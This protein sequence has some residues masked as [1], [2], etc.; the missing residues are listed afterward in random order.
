MPADERFT[1][2][3]AQAWPGTTAEHL[4]AILLPPD[5]SLPAFEGAADAITVA[6]LLTRAEQDLAHP[7][8]HTLAHAAARYVRDGDREEYQEQLFARQQRLSR[9]V[10]AAVVTESPQWVDEVADGVVLLCEQSSWCWPAHDDTWQRHGSVLPSVTDPYLDLGAGEV[11]GQ[12]AWIDHVLG[13]SLDERFPGLRSRIRHETRVRVI[14]PFLRRRDWQWLGLDGHVNNWNP[15]IHGNVLV[16]A[17]RLVDDLQLRATVVDLAIQGLDRYVA[18]LPVD[19]AIDEGY[20]YWWNGACRAVEALDLLRH[21]TAGQLD[22]TTIPALRE[23]LAFPHRM[24]LA[25][26]WYLNLADGQARPPADQPW[27]ALHRAALAIGAEPAARHAAVHRLPGAPVANEREGL[28]RLLRALGDQDWRLANADA[29]PLPRDVWLESIQVL[30]ARPAEGSAQGL[31]LAVKGGHNGEHHNHNDVGQVVI[32][33][34]GVPMVVDAGRTTYN[35][36][37]FG[38]DRYLIPTMNSDWHSVPRI[39]ADAQ[40]PG[41]RYAARSLEPTITDTVSGLKLD[42]A[43]A[44]PGHE[45][46][47]WFRS[48]YLDRSPGQVVITD[49]WNLSRASDE[50][51]SLVRYI[52]ASDVHLVPG[53]ATIT[54]E[55]T[56]TLSWD[57]MV[58]ATLDVLHLEDQMLS[59]VWGDRL[60]RLT[61]DVGSER[62]GTLTVTAQLKEVPASTVS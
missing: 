54:G 38:P 60:T 46:E 52:L 33:V 2:P 40:D 18:V 10:V 20:A 49:A 28:G 57:P 43:G 37:T 53:R 22:A 41:R 44:Y 56:L 6:D 3:L 13:T 42:L 59:D 7:W 5:Q 14:E 27:H 47:S 34:N 48:A 15:W 58:L 39:G 55:S 30:V 50:E 26:D 1:G 51:P 8:P 31:T 21:A 29:S 12:L 4:K 23:T 24:H 16:A 45:H 36:Q 19:G 17:L 32:A 25:D 35:A 61:L 11:A 62:Q 9:A